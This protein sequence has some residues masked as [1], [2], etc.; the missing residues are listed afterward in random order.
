M[1]NKCLV[2]GCNTNYCNK[3]TTSP[4]ANKLPVFRLP[5]IDNECSSWLKAIPYQIG[6][7][8]NGPVI[9]EQH[10]PG[11]YTTTTKKGKK[12]ILISSI[13]VAWFPAK[14]HTEASTS[15]YLLFTFFSPFFV[16]FSIFSGFDVL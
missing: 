14:L 7:L 16:F 4:V 6:T 15:T 5:K 13:C 10:W 12:N 8:P 2:P 1:E 9:C 11:S 3:T